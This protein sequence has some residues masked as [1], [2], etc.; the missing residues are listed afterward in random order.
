[1]RDRICV[2]DIQNINKSSISKRM[3]AIIEKCKDSDENGYSPVEILME[4]WNSDFTDAEVLMM[5]AFMG[6]VVGE[7]TH[8]KDW[9]K[10]HDIKKA[11]D[12]MSALK[13][14]WGL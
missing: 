10:E 3:Q 5:M 11:D 12:D 14:K 8:F 2:E 7:T 1:M 4:I 13:K 9:S 6:H